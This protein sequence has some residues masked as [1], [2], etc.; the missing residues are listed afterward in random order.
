MSFYT[1]SLQGPGLFLTSLAAGLVP[2]LFFPNL[3][4]LSFCDSLPSASRLPERPGT[5]V[6]LVKWIFKPQAIC[7]AP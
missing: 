6:T 5:C 7:A 4:N 1:T 3:P 2:I